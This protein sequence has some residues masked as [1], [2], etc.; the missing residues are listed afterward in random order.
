MNIREEDKW[1]INQIS[2][3]KTRTRCFAAKD[4]PT[5]SEGNCHTSN[6]ISVVKLQ[7]IL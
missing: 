6:P 7:K 1:K 4:M 2:Q 3:M 5:L